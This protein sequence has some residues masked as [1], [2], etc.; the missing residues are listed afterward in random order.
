MTR[1]IVR[2]L[3]L[4]LE[5]AERKDGIETLREMRCR[6]QTGILHCASRWYQVADG[7]KQGRSGHVSRPTGL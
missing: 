3:T 7:G 4:D 6:A 1:P 5:K 2:G